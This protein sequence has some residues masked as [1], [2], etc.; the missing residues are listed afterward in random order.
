MKAITLTILKMYENDNV[1]YLQI[2]IA[3]GMGRFHPFSI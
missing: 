3:T 2:I 1:P